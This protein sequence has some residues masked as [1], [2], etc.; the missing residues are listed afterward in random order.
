MMLTIMW[1]SFILRAS[2]I[3]TT[4]S[5]DERSLKVA[6]KKRS[7]LSLDGIVDPSALAADL[8]RTILSVRQRSVEMPR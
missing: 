8:E 2:A 6:L 5:P 3:P 1:A 7:A 4:I